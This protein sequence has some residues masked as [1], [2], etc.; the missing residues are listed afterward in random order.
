MRARLLYV[1]MKLDGLL[2]KWLRR[3]IRNQEWRRSSALS[4][5]AWLTGTFIVFRFV[6]LL[7][8]GWRVNCVVSLCF[9]AVI[10]V[11]NKAWIWRKRRASFSISVGWAAVWWLGFFAFNMAIA[12]LLIDQVETGIKPARYILGGVGL[13]MNPLVFMFRDKKVFK[14]VDETTPKA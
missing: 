1:L 8:H 14:R 5:L 9:D 12:W 11:A 6:A 4:G 10:Y 2:P 13:A 7:G 3:L